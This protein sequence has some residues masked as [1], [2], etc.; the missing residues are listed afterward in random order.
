MFV[1]MLYQLTLVMFRCV[2]VK[3]NNEAS[4]AVDELYSCHIT[5]IKH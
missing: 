3:Q 1:S 4:H 5:I 2:S